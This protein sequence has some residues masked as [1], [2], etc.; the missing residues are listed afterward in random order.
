MFSVL[1]LKIVF[2][3]VVC[4]DLLLDGFWWGMKTIN[5]SNTNLPM[6]SASSWRWSTEDADLL[7]PLPFQLVYNSN[8][9]RRD[10]RKEVS[11]H[12]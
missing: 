3:S 7:S 8:S 4:F 10:W 12:K 1:S 2:F 6:D 5:K 9:L 11:R